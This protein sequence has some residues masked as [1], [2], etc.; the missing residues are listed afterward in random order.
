MQRIFATDNLK[1]TRVL[2]ANFP[3][4]GHFNPLTGLAVHL[5]ELGCDVRW[6]T[7]PTY[8]EKINRMGIPFYPLKKAVDISADKDIDKVFPDR[9]K[10]KSQISKLKFDMIHAFIL[11]AKDYFDDILEIQKDFDFEIMICDNCFAGIA[12]VKE[13]LQLP[14]LAIGVIPLTQTSKDLPPMG[15][16]LTPSYSPFGK[17]RQ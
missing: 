17:I 11:P 7:S 14:V 3:A 4:D 8:A 15:L 10:H 5:K 6:Y 13:K 2:F 16:G 1:G 12:L 9:K